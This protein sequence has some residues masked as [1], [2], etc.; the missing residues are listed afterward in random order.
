M[1]VIDKKTFRLQC[2]C[3]INEAVSILEHGSGY[4][5]SWGAGKPFKNFNVTWGDDSPNGPNIKTA[6]CIMCGH[7]P[8]ISL[9]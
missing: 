9:S 2:P 3:G 8:D 6:K 4:G 1:G 7:T 5:S